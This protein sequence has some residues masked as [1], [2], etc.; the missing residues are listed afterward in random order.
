MEVSSDKSH[1]LMPGNKAIANINN[2]RIDSED[3]HEFLGITIDSKLK[4]ISINFAKG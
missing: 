3:T 1:F 4:T 2:N